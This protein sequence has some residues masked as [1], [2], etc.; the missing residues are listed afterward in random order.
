MRTT[1]LMLLLIYIFVQLDWYTRV[2][3]IELKDNKTAK[4]IIFCYQY[5]C[6]H[7]SFNM[8]VYSIRTSVKS[9]YL[10]YCRN[11]LVWNTLLRNSPWNRKLNDDLF[12]FKIKQ[13]QKKF[14]K[15]FY[16]QELNWFF[17]IGIIFSQNNGVFFKNI[18]LIFNLCWTR[19]RDPCN[20]IGN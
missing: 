5:V 18:L 15:I 14:I 11:L 17:N 3:L 2:I 12:A 8:N 6:K 19:K 10:L 20:V 9:D 4:L 7:T 13:Q 1:L 16:K